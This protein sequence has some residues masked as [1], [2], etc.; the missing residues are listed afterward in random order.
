[1]VIEQNPAAEEVLELRRRIAELEEELR[2]RDAFIV[3]AA[4]ELRNPISPLSLHL[5]RLLS[6]S[7]G[8]TDDHISA[9]WLAQQLET[10]SKRLVRFM[11]ALNRILDVSKMR[12]GSIDLVRERV[13]LVEV[14]REVIASYERELAASRSELSF[15][16]DGPVVGHW[17][18]MRLEQVVS[19]LVSNAIRYGESGPI[20]VSVRNY[21]EVAELEVTDHG[22]GIRDEDQARI[23][24]RFERA[25]TRHRGGF[26]VGL[27]IVRQLCLAM[28]G[29]VRVRSRAGEGSTFTVTLPREAGGSGD[30]R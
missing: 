22:V 26:G 11:S 6:M 30:D 8:A 15:S 13:D 25:D 18:R 10:F 23:F 12:G 1:M 20:L 14:A 27:W 16:G 7:R 4:H 28:G 2:Q 21:P 9:R 5:Q 19:N 17:D 3:S 29:D 24:E